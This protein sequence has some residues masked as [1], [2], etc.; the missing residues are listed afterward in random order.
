MTLRTVE[1]TDFIAD[2]SRNQLRITLRSIEN[3]VKSIKPPYDVNRVRGCDELLTFNM[4][5]GDSNDTKTV[6]GDIVELHFVRT[7]VI[8][9]TDNCE[10][11]LCHYG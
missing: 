1:T 2:D 9:N 6:A 5:G 3:V 10:S 4:L 11:N 7:V 8:N